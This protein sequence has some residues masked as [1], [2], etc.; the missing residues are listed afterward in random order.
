MRA[1]RAARRAAYL[2]AKQR[3]DAERLL[4]RQEAAARREA[5]RLDL[6]AAA[7]RAYDHYLRV[8]D[9]ARGVSDA[10]GGAT[11]SL[12]GAEQQMVVALAHLW[13]AAPATIAGLRRSC[14]P[15]TGVRAADY[16]A[17]S[18]DLI[19][20]LR[21]DLAAVRKQIRVDL[22][23]PEERVL[24]GFGYL[25]AGE[26][27]NADTLTHFQ[28]LVA[29]QD[30]AVL[31]DF[32]H[33]DSRRL[34]WEIG[35]GWGGFAHA[36]KKLCPGVTYLITSLPD[37]FL[38]SAVYLMTV[39]PGCRCRFF[40]PVSPAD[41]WNDWEQ[42]DFI[43]VPEHAVPALRPPRVDL[44][45]DIAA[46]LNMSSDRVAA[47]VQRAFDAGARYFYSLLSGVGRDEERPE[48]WRAIERLYW[49]HPIPPRVKPGWTP[50]YA[51]LIGW[52]RIL[53]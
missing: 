26:R 52:R 24:G 43:F 37:L 21:R 44:A 41:V 20:R 10:G 45:V 13:N 15:I 1:D 46:L 36:F 32:R 51:H 50:D 23:V 48:P 6:E 35:G 18:G 40:D 17:P 7:A 30:A 8:R 16:D 9:W 2:A 38:V 14:E 42:A 31:P 34:V 3:D 49:P 29:L 39:H 47:H 33:A 28:A 4:R 22:W 5:E 11:G 12:T 53:V 27:Y 25:R 19:A